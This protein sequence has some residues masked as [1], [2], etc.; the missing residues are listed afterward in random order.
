MGTYL[1]K[2][3]GLVLVFCLLLS[4]V[5]CTDNTID[6][7]SQVT[8]SE[9]TEPE[10]TEPEVTEPETTETEVT[11][12][13]V[14]EPEVT[15]PEVTEPEV[16]E[17]EVTEPEVTEPEVTEPEPTEP[18]T[19]EPE[20]KVIKH[21]FGGAN[22]EWELDTDN[23]QGI[24]SYYTTYGMISTIQDTALVL[25]AD[26]TGRT[27]G[28]AYYALNKS[29][30]MHPGASS[31]W[32]M[33][34]VAL[35]MEAS[36]TL[37]AVM[38][39]NKPDGAGN[40]VVVKFLK[41]SDSG[42]LVEKN[43]TAAGNH[44]MEVE[45][46]VQKGDVIY[47]LVHHNN[48]VTCDGATYVLEYTL[49]PGEESADDYNID[50]A[51]L[52]FRDIC[53]MADPETQTY[54]M[55][56]FLKSQSSA[57]DI[58]C[59]QSKDLQNWGGRT[60]VFYN[61]GQYDQSWAP[62]FYYLNGGYYMVANLKGNTQA[63]DLRGC[64]ILKAD[65]ANGIYEIIS[66]RITPAEWEC[67]D[68][69]LYYEDGIPYM[70]YCREWTGTSNNNGEMYAVRLKDDLTGVYPGASHKKLF[71]A[72]DHKASNDGITD[73]CWMYRASNGDLIM[74][75]SK[76]VDDKYTII[77][78]RPWLDKVSGYWTHDK[79]TLFAND[80]GHPMVFTDF[81]G[82]LRI[83]FHENSGSKGRETPVIYYLE[84][85]NGVLRI[86]DVNGNPVT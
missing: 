18:E 6:D 78:S 41:N 65:K 11:E 83:A 66:E 3:L 75:W 72:K 73:G 51:D 29:G 74:L 24:W 30:F 33:P 22:G 55:I 25:N 81:D 34:I 40:G 14:T 63:G 20:D 43:L 35:T 77:T 38:N 28:E 4:M 15:E 8:E 64:Y 23:S 32:S 69:H 70:I 19:T 10:Y 56:G 60:T 53:V 42:L 45:V 52:P 57:Q 84:D 80:G 21:T 62:E 58:V 49:V 12:P 71:S 47:F 44:N 7:S 31:P 67:L 68:G 36:G 82:N 17:P 39:A 85:N 61:N 76:Y 79:G 5:A 16:T 27:T 2:L 86:K 59:Y 54:Y 1:N 9:T 26:Q 46:E 13:E 50:L 37:K 48:D